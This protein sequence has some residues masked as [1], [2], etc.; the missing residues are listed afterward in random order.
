[1]FHILYMQDPM[2]LPIPQCRAS[3][4]FSAKD[5]KL[6]YQRAYAKDHYNEGKKFTAPC[7]YI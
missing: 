6:K 1:M 2:F 7:G 3:Y 4:T 5:W